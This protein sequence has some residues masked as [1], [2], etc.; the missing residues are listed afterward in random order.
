MTNLTMSDQSPSAAATLKP[1]DTLPA[2]QNLTVRIGTR[3]LEGLKL[4]HNTTSSSSDAADLDA[5]AISKSTSAQSSIELHAS[6]ATIRSALGGATTPLTNGTI[7]ASMGGLG[8]SVGA[9]GYF[10][11]VGKITSATPVSPA[12]HLCMRHKRTADEGTNLK[13]G[14]VSLYSTLIP[15]RPSHHMTNSLL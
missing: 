10:G 13:L 5:A 12:R 4:H 14:Q 15:W 8:G 2:P 1:C 3:Q 9:N 11:P 6:D 7:A